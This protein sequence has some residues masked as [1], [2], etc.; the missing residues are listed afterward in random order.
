M[1]GRKMK[2][3]H[4]IAAAVLAAAA[5]SAN[6]AID[7]DNGG[8]FGGGDGSGELFVSVFRNVSGQE[9]SY[10][11]DTGITASQLLSGSVADGTVLGNVGSFFSSATPGSFLFNAAAIANSANPGEFGAIFTSSNDAA[12]QQFAAAQSGTTI[13]AINSQMLTFANSANGSSVDYANNDDFANLTAASGGY[14]ARPDWGSNFGGAVTFSTEGLLDSAL[15]LWGVVINED[16]ES[17]SRVALG[18]LT[19]DSA[20]GNI[21]YSTGAPSQ[22]PVPAAVWLLGSALV[23]MSAIRR[24][25]RDGSAP[26][27]A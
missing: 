13:G 14:H 1:K 11:I 16:F 27:A 9:L 20:T 10:L 21:V 17:Y 8:S 3:K 12:V 4:I 18:F 23:G 6:A 19:A 5:S 24:R 15:A 26:V 25:R 22:V 2:L 7:T